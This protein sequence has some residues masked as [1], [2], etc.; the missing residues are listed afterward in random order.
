M[1]N[2]VSSPDRTLYQASFSIFSNKRANIPENG[3]MR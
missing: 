1:V 3:S 2:E